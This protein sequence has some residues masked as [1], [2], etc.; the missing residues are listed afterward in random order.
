MPI[1]KNNKISSNRKKTTGFLAN[2]WIWMGMID[3]YKI[4]KQ[5]DR[6]S[7][8]S[9]SDRKKLVNLQKQIIWHF[10][11]NFFLFPLWFLSLLVPSYMRGRNNIW[12]N[13]RT[14]GRLI[15]S[16]EFY[17]L[18][19]AVLSQFVFVFLIVQLLF[20]KGP[21]VLLLQSLV[22]AMAGTK[23]KPKSA[24]LPIKVANFFIL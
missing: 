7:G 1:P 22:A 12:T 15:N 11:K 3:S 24:A 8:K 9:K 16:R 23:D 10:L 4:L 13:L 2:Y 18:R 5:K 17:P 20:E 6:S 21:V 14:I 19:I